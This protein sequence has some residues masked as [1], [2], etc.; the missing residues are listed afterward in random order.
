VAEAVLSSAFCGDLWS[1]RD[2]D[3]ELSVPPLGRRFRFLRASKISRNNSINR[4]LLRFVRSIGSRIVG[5]FCAAE[6]Q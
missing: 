2:T 4:E 6:A 3:N 1:L 5:P